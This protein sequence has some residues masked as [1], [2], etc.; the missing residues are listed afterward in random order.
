MILTDIKESRPVCLIEFAG[1]T[2]GFF[3]NFVGIV[4]GMEPVFHSTESALKIPLVLIIF[5]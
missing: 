4:A 1:S 2:E 3:E 5:D